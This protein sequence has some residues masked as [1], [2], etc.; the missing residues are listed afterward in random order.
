MIAQVRRIS[1]IVAFV[2]AAV[3]AWTT[4]AEAADPQI[5][6]APQ[7]TVTNAQN[8]SAMQLVVSGT[9]TCGQPFHTSV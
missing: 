3:S 4:A 8:L 1:L 2:V 9:A 7:V 6:A 5:S